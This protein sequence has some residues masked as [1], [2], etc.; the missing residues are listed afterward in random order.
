M[1]LKQLNY[2]IA[3]ARYEGFTNAANELYVCQSALS[4][5]IKAMEAELGVQLVDRASRQFQLTPEGKMLYDK[6]QVAMMRINDYLEELQDCIH[7][8]SGKIIVGIPPVISTIYFAKVIHEFRQLHPE[9][10]LEIREEGANT[11]RDAVESAEVDIGVVILPFASEGFDVLPVFKARNV[12]IVSTRHPLAERESV[13]F[14]EL[15][16]ER[17]I[18]LNETYMLYNRVQ[19]L[20]KS[21]G[22]TP[23]IKIKSTQWDFVAEMVS[24]NEGVAI[25]PEPILDRFNSDKIK[26]LELTDP[27]FPWDIALIVR[28]D[29]Y[30]SRPICVFED[31]VK[32][33]GNV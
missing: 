27:A 17:F 24:L 2:F 16:T 33:R 19:E 5:V 21:A 3:L 1:N 8:Q 28:K 11:V 30:R 23:N 7:A 32:E 25:L 9:I 13:S 26:K 14:E 10:L 20:C 29:K 4:K 12:L 31:F 6:G 15:K 22:F 18:S